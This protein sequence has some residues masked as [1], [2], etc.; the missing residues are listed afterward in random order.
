MA[1]AAAVAAAAGVVGGAAATGA[2]GGARP[3][4]PVLQQA[5][6]YLSA[7]SSARF[8]FSGVPGVRF[9]CRRDDAAAVPC[10]SP[11]VYETSDGA[12]RFSVVAVDARGRRSEPAQRAWFVDTGAPA[13][14]RLVEAPPAVTRS[15]RAR[16]VVAAEEGARM[17]CTLDGADVRCRA[18]HL[19]LG[20]GEHRFSAVALDAAGNRGPAAE[21]VWRV[22]TTPPAA[23]EIE[24]GNGPP[25]AFT[26]EAGAT[27]LC[28]LDSGP[29]LACASPHGYPGPFTDGDHAFAVRARD[30]AGN[31]GP[32][33]TVHWTFD[34]R[35]YR[36][37][38]LAQ[39]GLSG[40][41]RLGETQWG[42]A[43]AAR[44]ADG[45]Y[46]GGVTLGVAG[47]FAGDPDPAAEFDGVSGEALLPGPVL[48]ESG[49]LE[50][51][52][53]LRS[54]IAALRDHTSGN[55]WI[56]GLRNSTGMLTCRAAGRTPTN[57]TVPVA[58]LAGSWH[59]LAMTKEGAT[60]TCYLDGKPA[61]SIGGAP[62]VS[63]V[64]PWHLMNNGTVTEQYA[65]GR[66]DDI[67]IY[68]H[69]LREEDINAHYH[70][71]RSS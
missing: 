15:T 8:V 41:W 44:G 37:T 40:Y 51:W 9:E 11:V 5:P 14:P 1:L 30:A 33:A 6:P 19:G 25:F 53:D 55:G 65:R 42:P 12:H 10:T 3:P 29:A 46:T 62:N 66:A 13:A 69:A 50:G 71:G 20:E 49:T 56:L 57:T 23:P 21:H 16:F 48:E 54:G 59:H 35:P 64:A 22:D 18:D 63:S 68:G 28:A 34:V 61:A 58:G 24:S 38:V 67:A 45:A 26:G 4:A 70:A 31:T 36:T 17:R 47:A 52:F 2:G 60:V 7:A 39:P 43:A 27:F 32:A